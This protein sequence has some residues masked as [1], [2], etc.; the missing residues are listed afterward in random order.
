LSS[1][2]GKLPPGWGTHRPEQAPTEF[3]VKCCRFRRN[4][5]LRW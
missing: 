5:H 1:K 4:C 3:V 2:H